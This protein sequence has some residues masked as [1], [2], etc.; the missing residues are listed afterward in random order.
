MGRR[1]QRQRKADK[2]GK[3]RENVIYGRFDHFQVTPLRDM[4]RKKLSLK[5]AKRKSSK[6]PPRASIVV[7]RRTNLLTSLLMALVLILSGIVSYKLMS[8]WFTGK[9][10]VPTLTKSSPK[11]LKKPKKKRLKNETL[12]KP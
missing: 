3:N 4:P 8:R 6:N 9:P 1:V 7:Q 10:L 11:D 5:K 2:F 12:P